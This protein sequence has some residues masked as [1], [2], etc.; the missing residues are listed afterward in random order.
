MN[1]LTSLESLVI[2][3]LNLLFFITISRQRRQQNPGPAQPAP[4]PQLQPTPRRRSKPL[5]PWVI[6]WILQREERGCYR[7]LLDEQQ[8]TYQVTRIFLR[9]PAAF[10]YLSEERIHNRRKKSHTNFR[11]PLEVG[12]KLAVTPQTPV[13]RRKLHFTTVPLEGS[14]NYHLQIRPKV[15][16]AS[17]AEFQDEYFCC[18]TNPEE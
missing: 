15:C 5:N 4:Q 9:M 12:L 10:F 7:T 2:I 14:Q 13:H 3:E 8:L 17:L 6:P 1:F 11:K 16:R 18:P